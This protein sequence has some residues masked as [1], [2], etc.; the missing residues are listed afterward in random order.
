MQLSTNKKRTII[1][2]I[3]AL[4]RSSSIANSRCNCPVTFPP[5][6]NSSFMRSSTDFLMMC[7]FSDATLLLVFTILNNNSH[8]ENQS[9]IIYSYMPS[10]FPHFFLC[11][12]FQAMSTN[13][14]L[15]FTAG[16]W[17]EKFRK[18]AAPAS[19]NA[20]KLSSFV[21]IPPTINLAWPNY[22]QWND[23]VFIQEKT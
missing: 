15:A 8:L 4:W 23:S 2:F 1:W 21:L 3:R 12:E 14:V 18:V 7:A 17:N 22:C 11:F 16:S 6:N 13:L 20:P 10:T 9:K 19:T 5:V